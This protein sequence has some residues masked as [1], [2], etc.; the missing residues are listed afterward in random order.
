MSSMNMIITIIGVV[1]VIVGYCALYLRKEDNKRNGTN[2][3]VSRVW[4]ACLA[5][6]VVLIACGCFGGDN[7]DSSE[8]TM[9]KCW[10]CGKK[11]SFQMDGSYYCFEHYNDRLWG[12]FD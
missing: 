10:I 2:K 3:S 4:I 9:G 5:I 11:G 8:R 12:R 1:L 7:S 6:G